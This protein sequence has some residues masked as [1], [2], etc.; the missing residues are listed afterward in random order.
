MKKS[1]LALIISSIV[2]STGCSSTDTAE[3]PPEGG[4]SPEMKEK[5]IAAIESYKADPNYGKDAIENPIR[6]TEIIDAMK[7][8]LENADWGYANGQPSGTP[9]HPIESDISNPEL[10]FWIDKTRDQGEGSIYGIYVN[11]IHVGEIRW[12]NGS[13]DIYRGEEQVGSIDP[14][15]EGQ[16]AYM[17]RLDNGLSDYVIINSPNDGVKAVNVDDIKARIE[18]HDIDKNQLKIKA[19]DA[20][21]RVKNLRS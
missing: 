18:S 10:G 16:H 5:V 12:Q 8:V 21:T 15:A 14:I 13:G 20:K 6:D 4:I 7:T 1:L 3:Q 19:R 9:S 11:G 2:V 17:V